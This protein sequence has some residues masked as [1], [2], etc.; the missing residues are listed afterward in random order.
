MSIYTITSILITITALFSYINRKF[1]KLPGSIG[2]M[3]MSLMV[4]V[5]MIIMKKTGFGFVFRVESLILSI[6]FEDLLLKGML[7][8]LLFAG[9]LHV[10]INDLIENSIEISLFA[11]LG[12]ILSTLCTGILIYGLS[13]LAGTG[14]RMEHCF[15][16]GALISP[17]DPISVLSILKD[18]GAPRKLGIK[19]SGESLFNDGFGVVVFMIILQLVTYK[20]GGGDIPGFISALD[21]FFLKGVGGIFFGLILGYTAYRILKSIDHFEVEVLITLAVVAGGYTLAEEIHLSGPLSMV[22]AG[23][24]IG[25]RGRKLAMSDR[26]REHLDAFW[27]LI[28]EILNALLFVLIG[29]EV[30]LITFKSEQI[31]FGIAAIAI[32]LSARFASI[33]LPV[34]LLRIWRDYTE[35]ALAIM[36]LGGLRGGISVALALSIPEEI[37]G[38][39]VRELILTMTYFVVAF[40]ILVQGLAVRRLLVKKHLL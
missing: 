27:R 21:L 36:T 7:G 8:F 40:S 3:L 24:M 31:L 29:L 26:T 17:T 39:S 16:F 30:F 33:G 32:V 13:L 11:T 22:I 34:S 37:V 18:A 1:L 5:I 25:N 12:V 15:L 4:A 38:S 2:V 10:D 23:L 20:G 35:N 6:P 14:L 9:A 19:I 28:D